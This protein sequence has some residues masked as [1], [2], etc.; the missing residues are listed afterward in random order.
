[1]ILVKLAAIMEAVVKGKFDLVKTFGKHAVG[2][3][4]GTL[5]LGAVTLPL[6]T[7]A[8]PK[9]P[10]K[11]PQKSSENAS[12]NPPA[13]SKPAAEKPG[14]KKAD[15]KPKS[16]MAGAGKMVPADLEFQGH[17]CTLSV[18][19]DY[20]LSE[21]I[22][23]EGKLFC[24][25]GPIHPDIKTSVFNV[26]IVPSPKGANLPGE[27]ELM[28][29]ML[30][31][32]K[33]SLKEYKETKEPLFTNGGHSFKGV[34]FAGK[35]DGGEKRHGFVYLTQDKDTFFI[36]FAQ[37]EEP[38]SDKT[39]PLLIKSAQGC[40]IKKTQPIAEAEKPKVEAK[41]T[42]VHAPVK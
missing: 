3:A 38:F 33:T 22:T 11:A 28:D 5:V 9:A 6:P 13:K 41:A 34:S 30:K 16:A 10:A 29:T 26:T 1:M 36:L 27:R 20:Q 39:L 12:E 15:E 37:D 14:E 21:Y 25:K 32:Q 24:F 19:G 4:A 31:H 35:G 8:Q 40:Q 23:H 42:A 18:P 7:A 17:S 2:L